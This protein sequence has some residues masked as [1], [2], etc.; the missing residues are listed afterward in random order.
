MGLRKNIRRFLWRR[1]QA[2]HAAAA[3]TR[4]FDWNWL[5]TPYSR[6]ALVSL[7]AA[8]RPEGR[9]LEI[10]CDR[11]DVFRAVPA[12][13][14]VGVDPVRGGTVRATS[15]DY[16]RTSRETFDVV[17]IDGLHTYEQVRRDVVNA[18]DRVAPGG[19]IVLHDMLPHDWVEAHVPRVTPDSWTGDVWKA[20]F[21]M[22]A[23]PGLDFRIVLID[24]GCLVIRAP[25]PRL[26]LADRRSEMTGATFDFLYD[27]IGE[28]PLANWDE[29]RNWAG[30]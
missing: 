13:R 20:A 23:T 4:A 22:Q 11:D 9:Y 7:L 12:R 3:S 1:E 5:A 2:R 15:D 10:G 29:F 8:S 30:V 26:T 14:K 19:W 16:F 27:H 24:N 28:L 18:L 17:Y 6:I 21:D 25:E